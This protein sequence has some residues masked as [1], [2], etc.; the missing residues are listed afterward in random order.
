MA[1]G[2]DGGH[3]RAEEGPFEGSACEVD[4][5]VHLEGVVHLKGPEFRDGDP[6]LQLQAFDDHGDRVASVC[7]L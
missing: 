3:E 4:Q 2:R 7:R 5:E 6:F 1:R